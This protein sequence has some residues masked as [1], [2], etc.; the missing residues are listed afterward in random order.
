MSARPPTFA[1]C[2]LSWREFE[3]PRVGE[4][5]RRKGFAVRETGG[6]GADG[7][8]D[9]VLTKERE[10]T[11]VQCKLWR[12]TS[13][14]VAVVRELFGVMAAQGATTGVVVTSGRFSPAAVEFA[15]GRNVDLIDGPALRLL[16]GNEP[17][18]QD[19]SAAVTFPSIESFV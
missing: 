14:G 3:I 4:A 18:F 6:T 1:I 9:F 13:V 7:G 12:S 11:L 5:Y 19:K 8:V 16:I 2:S 15:S 10:V 17:R